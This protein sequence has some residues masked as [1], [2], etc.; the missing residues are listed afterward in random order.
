MTQEMVGATD[1]LEA[2]AW[3]A[4]FLWRSHCTTY[5]GSFYSVTKVP[6]IS[7]TGEEEAWTEVLWMPP[8]GTL[9]RQAL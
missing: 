7:V 4:V 8:Q 1:Q 5:M 2:S 9:Y 3:E 6:C